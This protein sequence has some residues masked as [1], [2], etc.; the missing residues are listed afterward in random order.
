LTFAD[1]RI[2][3]DYRPLFYMATIL[4]VEWS[5]L[6]QKWMSW[7]QNHPNSLKWIACA[8]A[9]ALMFTFGGASSSNFLYFQF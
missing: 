1:G 7:T 6:K 4:L 9:I 5:D 2:P 3:I 8:M